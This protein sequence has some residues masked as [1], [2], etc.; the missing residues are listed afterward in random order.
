[1]KLSTVKL[2]SVKLSNVKLKIQLLGIVG[3][4]TQATLVVSIQLASAEI[5][6]PRASPKASVM[7]EIGLTNVSV[8]YFSPAVNKRNVWGELVSYDKIWRTGANGC[9]KLT[10]SESAEIAGK[11][12]GAGSY[13]IFTVPSKNSAWKVMINEDETLSGT[14]GYDAKKDV[15]S[16]SITPEKRPFRERL[17]FLF[18]DAT[19]TTGKLTMAWENIALV[20]PIKVE[21]AKHA[22]ANI[23]QLKSDSWRDYAFAARYMLEEQKNPTKASELVARSQELE[24]TWFNTWVKAQVLAAQ[25]KKAEALQ[26]AKEAQSM[27]DDSGFFK[28]LKPRIEASVKQWS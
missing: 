3:L 13:C 17:T 16:F 12:V 15:A 21:T 9:T 7:Q 5:S 23:E 2:S 6:L 26:F 25:G 10:L 4:L 14:D 18:E 20:L 22:V 19:P 8:D 24:K 28:A 27:G 11:N 1:M